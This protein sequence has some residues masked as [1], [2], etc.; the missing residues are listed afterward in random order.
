MKRKLRTG[1]HLSNK[2]LLVSTQ[3]VQVKALT[4]WVR[5]EGSRGCKPDIPHHTDFSSRLSQQI[6]QLKDH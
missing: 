2:G 1:K 4:A 3:T 6:E 5:D